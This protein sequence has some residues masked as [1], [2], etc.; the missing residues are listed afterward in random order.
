MYVVAFNYG[1]CSV[2]RTRYVCKI[3]SL[4]CQ[5]LL[6]G[7]CIR[8]TNLSQPFK[9]SITYKSCALTAHIWSDVTLGWS[10]RNLADT[11]NWNITLW[12]CA[13]TSASIHEPGVQYTYSHILYIYRSLKYNST[14]AKQTQQPNQIAS[15]IIKFISRHHKYDEYLKVD[16]SSKLN[17]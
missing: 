1:M 2:S 14:H 9:T 6:G 4:R 8:Y 17:N 12:S 3:R 10:I 7:F 11:F 5:L 15:A 13:R 16:I